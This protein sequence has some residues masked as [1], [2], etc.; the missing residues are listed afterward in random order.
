MSGGSESLAVEAERIT[1]VFFSTLVAANAES[2]A[3]AQ[4]AARETQVLLLRDDTGYPGERY[5]VDT[6]FQK[7]VECPVT[8]RRWPM[9][10]IADF[11]FWLKRVLRVEIVT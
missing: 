6:G 4:A 5:V 9:P 1:A 7:R 10:A 11:C 3:I 2:S 8:N